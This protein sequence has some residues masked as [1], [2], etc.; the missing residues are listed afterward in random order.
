VDVNKSILVFVGQLR[1]SVFSDCMC[2]S[3]CTRFNA[4]GQSA[5]HGYKLQGLHWRRSLFKYETKLSA[6]SRRH[7]GALVDLAP[8]IETW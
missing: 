6:Q 5:L 8:Q 4:A 7:G 1:W 2:G 3:W